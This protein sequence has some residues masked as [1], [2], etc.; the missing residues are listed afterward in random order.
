MAY[1][2]NAWRA[3]LLPA[4]FK[5]DNKGGIEAMFHVEVSSKDSGRRVVT[6]EFPK[7]ELPYAEDMGR[8]AIEFTVR[9]YIICY[10]HKP[11]KHGGRQNEIELYR[12][13]YTVARD[14][15]MD[16]LDSIGPGVLQLPNGHGGLAP[17][18]VVCQRYRMTEE[19]RLGGYCTFDMSFIELGVAPFRETHSPRDN[20]M[21]ASEILR[22][23]VNNSM[24][25][26]QTRVG[27]GV[28]G[29][30][31]NAMSWRA[32]ITRPPQREWL[33]PAGGP[34]LIWN[35]SRMSYEYGAQWE[36]EAP[37]EGGPGLTWN[38]STQRWEYI[39]PQEPE[40]YPAPE[41]FERYEPEYEPE[42]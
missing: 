34:G 32:S 22:N 27:A 16:H 37:R 28:P 4:Y 29:G 3:K 21:Q 20:L 12:E 14:T 26:P 33:T 36:G 13:D 2:N 10:P 35:E 25:R 30:A 8:R 7:K 19:Q 17:I 11:E 6:H 15:L 39:R 9:G 1:I 42:E 38:E 41:E 31:S 23:R 40:E 24:Q 5:N 18:K